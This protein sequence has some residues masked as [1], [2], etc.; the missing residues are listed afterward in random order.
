M[1]VDANWFLFVEEKD[2]RWSFGNPDEE[3]K[4]FVI[5]F[6]TGLAQIGEEVFGENGVASI[7]FDLKKKSQ[8]LSSEI[9]IVNLSNKFYIIMSDPSITMKMINQQGGIAPEVEEILSAVLVGQAAILYATSI[10]EVSTDERTKIEKVWQDIIIDISERYSEDINQIVS[11]SSSN[12]SRLAFEDLLFL[13]YHLRKQPE[14]VKIISPKGWGLVS[15]YSGSAIPLEH[16]LEWDSVV[17]AGYLGIIISFITALFNSKPKNLA[18]G[19]QTVQT[20]FFINGDD[21]Y[22]IAIDSPFTQLILDPNFQTKF[23]SLQ[24][25]VIS[26]LQDALRKRI[27]E[28][29]LAA[30][31]EELEKQDLTSLL[32]DSVLSRKSLFERLFSRKKRLNLR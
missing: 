10:S 28:E 27:I 31:A 25:E 7:E 4:R 30:N 24:E 16:N 32:Q 26:D 19:T 23:F 14:L 1:K 3:F 9:F 11:A 12:F 17:L 5:N 22:F 20:L 29:I 21:N 8:V 2:I 18:F 15:H 6:L 13:H